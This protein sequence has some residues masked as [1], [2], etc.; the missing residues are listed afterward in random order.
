MITL[1]IVMMNENQSWH[2]DHALSARTDP[3]NTELTRAADSPVY[4]G[5]GYLNNDHHKNG[6]KQ[7][8]S[9]HTEW[10]TLSNGSYLF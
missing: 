1:I 4:H 3:P 2:I 9:V 10:T 7:L 5:S 8:L 6:T